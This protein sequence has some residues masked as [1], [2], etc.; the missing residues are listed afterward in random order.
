MFHIRVLTGGI[1][2]FAVYLAVSTINCDAQ[3]S[4]TAVTCVNPVSGTSFQS[5]DIDLHD[6]GYI[7]GTLDTQGRPGKVVVVAR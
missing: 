5:A 7:F 3:E 6:V 1:A 4:E 2:G